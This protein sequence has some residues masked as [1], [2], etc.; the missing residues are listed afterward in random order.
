MQSLDA[1]THYETII[2]TIREIRAQSGIMT[3]LRGLG[4][5]AMGAGPAHALY[6][7][8]YEFAKS[9]YGANAPGH[10]PIATGA[11]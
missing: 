8:S 9:V 11:A 7:A 6:F 1:A 2:G 3:T 10:H 4:A 5:M